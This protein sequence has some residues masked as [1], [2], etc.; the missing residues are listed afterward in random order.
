MNSTLYILEMDILDLHPDNEELEAFEEEER[1]D[2][3][4]DGGMRCPM[5][6][7]PSGA[8]W[9]TGIGSYWAHY[10]RYHHRRV[11]VFRCPR[12]GLKDIKMSEVKRHLRRTHRMTTTEGV[13]KETVLNTKFVDPKGFRRPRPRVHRE[14]RAQEEEQRRNLPPAPLFP[15]TE[16]HNPRDEKCPVGG[17]K[18]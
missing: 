5:P 1:G 16:D 13:T 2:E 18:K 14:E 6:G 10:H 11:V 8:H 12:C 3:W 4:P 7:C 17:F 9:F 15:L